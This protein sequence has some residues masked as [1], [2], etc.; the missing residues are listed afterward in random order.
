MSGL[1]S[2]PI[3]KA[4]ENTHNISGEKMMDINNTAQL[5]SLVRAASATRADTPVQASGATTAAA[6]VLQTNQ[7]VVP[8]KKTDSSGST[9]KKYQ[10]ESQHPSSG[11][12]SAVDVYV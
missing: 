12:G 8:N 1:S 3:E 5:G 10:A 9:H 7:T 11:R 6:T 2:L 4:N